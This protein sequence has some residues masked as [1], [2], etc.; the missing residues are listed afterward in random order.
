MDHTQ[1]PSLLERSLEPRKSIQMHE[2]DIL[3]IVN[4]LNQRILFLRYA[5]MGL[6]GGIKRRNPPT[7]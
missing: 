4:A 1:S 3:A 6:V 5:V 2:R 7:S